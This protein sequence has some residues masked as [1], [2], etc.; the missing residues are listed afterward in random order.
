MTTTTNARS[1]RWRLAAL[2]AASLLAL[3]LSACGAFGG[4]GVSKAEQAKREDASLEAAQCMRKHGVPMEVREGG[5]LSLD[6][7]ANIDS[8]TLEKA[9]KACKGL[10][11]AA[12]P[13]EA[14]EPLPAKEKQ[15]MLAE[16]QCMRERGWNQPDPEFPGNGK[17]KMKPPPNVDLNDPQLQKDMKECRKKAAAGEDEQP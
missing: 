7:D 13:E 6:P 15:R 5:G 2:T 11:E 12:E 1:T 14:G 10:L 17:V 9:E 4:D 8:A 3:L 16:A